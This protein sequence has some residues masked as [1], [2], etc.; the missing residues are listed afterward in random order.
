MSQKYE[1][2]NSEY[3]FPSSLSDSLGNCILYLEF[4]AVK[5]VC[6]YDVHTDKVKLVRKLRN[7]LDQ[8]VKQELAVME[9][10]ILNKDIR[11]LIALDNCS[12]RL[13]ASFQEENI[14][15]NQVVFGSISIDGVAQTNANDD[16]YQSHEQALV[17]EYQRLF[18]KQ[19][20][21]LREMESD[22]W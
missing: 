6:A 10:D 20:E 17:E 15:G 7:K 8:S 4:F 13:E 12:Q 5:S 22:Q 9:T 1:L 2:V 21:L 3:D 11:L 16:V 18:L 19:Q 14:L